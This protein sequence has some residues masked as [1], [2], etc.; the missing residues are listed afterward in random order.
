[1]PVDE[2]KARYE[3]MMQVLRANTLSVW[4]DKFLTELEVTRPN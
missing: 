3:Q 1:M 2:R 4:R